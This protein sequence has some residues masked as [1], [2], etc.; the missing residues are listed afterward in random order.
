MKNK[1]SGCGCLF[2]VVGCLVLVVAIIISLVV[3]F[4]IGTSWVAKRTYVDNPEKIQEVAKSIC[5]YKL[6][7]KFKPIV[8]IDFKIIRAAVFT[9][10]QDKKEENLATVIFLD[11]TLTNYQDFFEAKAMKFVIQKDQGG[12]KI[13]KSINLSDYSN[14]DTKIS[15][16]EQLIYMEDG[17]TAVTIYKGS[18]PKGDRR[19][20]AWYFTVGLTNSPADA[21]EV[22][23]SIG[24][25]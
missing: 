21:K 10:E 2:G 3:T 8:A 6:P 11:T 7:D 16:Q 5:D 24:K 1:K 18:F 4:F 15:R 12:R 19:V 22:I 20:Y 17:S 23:N 13:V 25:P 9:K 14:G